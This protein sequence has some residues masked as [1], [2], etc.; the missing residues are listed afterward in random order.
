MDYKKTEKKRKK[1]KWPVAV[2]QTPAVSVRLRCHAAYGTRQT[3]SLS[4]SCLRLPGDD[5]GR[6]HDSVPAASISRT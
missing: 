5:R 4:P 6:S 2:A 3:V 1:R